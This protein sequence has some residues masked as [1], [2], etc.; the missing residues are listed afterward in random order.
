[1]MAGFESL[2]WLVR[3]HPHTTPLGDMKRFMMMVLL[4]ALLVVMTSTAA[5]AGHWRKIARS[6]IGVPY[7][8]GASSPGVAFD[9]SG[10]TMWLYSRAF[11]V[12]LPHNS[13]G[14]DSVSRN[15][16]RPQLE[17]GDLLFYNWGG[18]GID[19]V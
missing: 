11:G 3:Y 7:V 18:G 6:Q 17:P 12:S 4:A 9:C 16:P 19:H 15:I 8:W 14:Q 1:M 10:F 2:T 13:A 5:L